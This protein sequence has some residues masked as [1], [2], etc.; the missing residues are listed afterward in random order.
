[1]LGIR[2][3]DETRRELEALARQQGRSKSAIV[4][5]A[6]RRYLTSIDL[7]G[8]ARR[9]SLAVD[10]DRAERDAISFIE[11]ATDIADDQ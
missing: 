8:E 1:M 4:R 6:L 3:D 9:Q 7:A 11:H 5:E 10:N 2:L